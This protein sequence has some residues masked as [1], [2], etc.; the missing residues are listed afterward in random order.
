MRKL[1]SNQRQEAVSL[2]RGGLTL[3]EIGD[4]Y[5]VTREAIRYWVDAHGVRS[6]EGGHKLKISDRRR[7]M[8]LNRDERYIEKYGFPFEKMKEFWGTGTVQK[9]FK[10]RGGAQ[11]RGIGWELTFAQWWAAW[12]ISGHWSER[13][14]GGYCMARKHDIGPYRI[15]NIYFCTTGQN[16]RDAHKWKSWAPFKLTI[17]LR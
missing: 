12:Q 11:R 10:C 17:P 8:H 2:F 1:N 14:P 7:A 3:Q 4:K 15:G 5:G 13:G 6:E 9:F 16:T